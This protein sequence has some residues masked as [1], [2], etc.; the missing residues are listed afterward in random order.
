[1]KWRGCFSFVVSVFFF[2]LF[3]SCVIG[4]NDTYAVEDITVTYT[5][6][7]VNGDNVFP[8][9]IDYACLSQYS[10]LVVEISSFTLRS[11]RVYPI[12]DIGNA[13]YFLISPTSSFS[14][15]SLPS[16]DLLKFVFI[17]LPSSFSWSDGITFTLTENYQSGIT[18][19][20]S[21][22]ITEN[23]TYDVTQYAEAVVDVPTSSG[24]GSSE[25]CNY[26]EDL[27]NIYHAIM[28]CGGVLLVLYFFYCIYRMIIKTAGSYK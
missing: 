13:N 10:Y 25:D 21:L 22:S 14:V 11:G 23:G 20:G 2:S 18:P 9:C 26:H 24:G 27:V 16:S 5:S 19:S 7:P 8:S 15:Y 1:M 4:Q 28:V 6:S 17:N 3:G 12:F